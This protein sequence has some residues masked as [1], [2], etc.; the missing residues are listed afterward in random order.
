MDSAANNWKTWHN[1]MWPT[2]YLIDKQ[3][4]LRRWWQGELNWQSATGEQEFRQTI[5]QLLKE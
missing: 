1:T 3:G 4:F 2:V 5:Q